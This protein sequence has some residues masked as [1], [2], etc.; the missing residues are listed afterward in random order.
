MR[1]LGWL[2]AVWFFS[3]I[4]VQA[5]TEPVLLKEPIVIQSNETFNGEG[6]RFSSCERPAFQLKGNGAVL[7][8]VTIEQCDQAI[9]PVVLI[10]GLGHQV[11]DARIN[12]VGT[13][14]AVKDSRGV[15]LIRPNVTGTGREEGISVHNSEATVIK[16]AIIKHT[17]DGIYIEDGTG[18]ELIRPLVMNSR[19][20][21]HLMFPTDVSITSPFLHH[22]ETGAM[23]MGTERVSIENGKI[24]DQI[25][26]TGMGL[27]LFEAVETTVRANAIYGNRVG[28]YAEKS[29][30]TAIHD[31]G[32]NGNDIGLRLKRADGM[33]LTGNDVTN[34]RYPVV[35]FEAADNVI[36]GNDWGGQTLDL[37]N[38][39]QS[40]IPYRAD[41]YLFLL[42][43]SYE[44]FE[45][46]Y[47]APGLMVLERVL[48]SP[49]EVTLT[50]VSPRETSFELKWNGTVE[51]TVLSGLLILLW[52]FGRKQD[53]YV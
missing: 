20:G 48:R 6:K 8:N 38:D 22:N 43:D 50:D 3:P 36:V 52:R 40:E 5:N 10:E 18:H 24:H 21:I 29:E 14:I 35:S 1:R 44:A 12:A 37:T 45:L 42:A 4:A 23:V 34:N 33:T 7:E 15:R 39:G 53:D 11:I 49:E 46:L 17:R 32:I 2:L 19:Y 25:G 9:G 28:I 31:N 47:G 16:G 13:G 27:M 26:A 41:P 30:W 51:A